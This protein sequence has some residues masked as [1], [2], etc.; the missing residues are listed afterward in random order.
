MRCTNNYEDYLKVTVEDVKRAG[1]TERYPKHRCGTVYYVS[2]SCEYVL[3]Y[4]Q[5]YGWILIDK[6]TYEDIQS[7]NISMNSKGQGSFYVPYVEIESVNVMLHRFV[8]N[9]AKGVLVD[10]KNHNRCCCI[11]ENLRFCNYKQNAL[12]CRRHSLIAN[13]CNSDSEV[14]CYLKYRDTARVIYKGTEL[15]EFVY[16]IENDF[17]KTLGLLIHYYIFGDITKAEMY[18]MNLAYWR[19]TLDN[20]PIAI[21]V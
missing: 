4:V 8:K 17:S 5:F 13:G 2:E 9:A 6:E 12:N 19:D 16:D 1:F 11:K 18:Q 7:I 20:T 10:H 14:D 21:A 3:A 15:E